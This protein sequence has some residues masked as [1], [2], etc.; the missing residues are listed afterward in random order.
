MRH[1]SVLFQFLFVTLGIMIGIVPSVRAFEIGDIEIHGFISQGYLITDNN[2]YMADTKGGTFQFDEMGLNFSADVT[3]QLHI[4]MQ[5]FSR[6]L[7]D[8]G[9]NE[10][11]LGYAFGDYRWLN[12]LGVRAGKIK[13]DYGLYSEIREMDMF[14]TL[15]MLPQSVYPEIWRDSFSNIN[16]VSFYGYVPGGFM[17]KF[18]YNFQIGAMDFDPDGGF[19][20]YLHH[21]LNDDLNLTDIDSDY[22]WFSNIQWHTPVQG[23][24][25]KGSYYR[26]EGMSAQGDLSMVTKEGDTFDTVIHYDFARKDGFTLSLEYLWKN[27][28]VSAEYSEDTLDSNINFEDETIQ[29]PPGGGPPETTSQGWYLS[30]SYRF[31]DW[32]ESALTYSEYYPNKDNCAVAIKIR[33]KSKKSGNTVSV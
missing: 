26:I 15:I 19:A 30:A 3:D 27:L 24:K 23:L 18:A 5:I 10:V 4:A 32:L 17:G 9:N 11:G 8:V 1:I 2:N 12:W 20:G 21:K 29:A 31:T 13:I 22:S 16:G 7:G 14:R 25:W 28:T 6:D 33:T